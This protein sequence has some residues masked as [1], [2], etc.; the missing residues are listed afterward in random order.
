VLDSQEIRNSSRKLLP[1]FRTY[2]P[3]LPYFSQ[4]ALAALR[5]KAR[6]EM[7]PKPFK[8]I[9]MITQIVFRTFVSGLALSGVL[10]CGVCLPVVASASDELPMKQVVHFADLDINKPAGAQVLYTRITAAARRVC[11]FNE[12]WNIYVQGLERSCM[13]RAISDAVKSVHAPLL[14]ALHEG[15]TLRLASN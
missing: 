3:W 10:L 1:N 5:A 2:G 13:T 6:P 7:S 8:E 9:A 14:T 4:H 12:S 11:S 15:K